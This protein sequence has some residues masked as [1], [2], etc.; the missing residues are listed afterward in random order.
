M[1]RS[2]GGREEGVAHGKLTECGGDEGPD[3]EGLPVRADVVEGRGGKV[4]GLERGA[5]GA[6]G[7]NADNHPEDTQ[8][9]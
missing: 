7:H 6:H 5:R 4:A 1:G 3:G 9:D 8:A 2:A